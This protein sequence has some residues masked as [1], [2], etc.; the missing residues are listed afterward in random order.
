VSDSARVE[1]LDA[2][3][4]LGQRHVLTRDLEHSQRAGIRARRCALRALGPA[5]RIGLRKPR[6]AGRHQRR[7]VHHLLLPA[8]LEMKAPSLDRP[9]PSRPSRVGRSS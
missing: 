8:H 7:R 9:R 5:V 6:R 1:L 2:L 4:K 3:G